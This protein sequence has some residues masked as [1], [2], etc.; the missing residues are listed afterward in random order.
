MA[1]LRTARRP[2]ADTKLAF[3]IKV[4][5]TLTYLDVRETPRW[6]DAVFYAVGSTL[7]DKAC[8]SQLRYLRCD[9]FDVL[10]NVDTLELPERTLGVG[11][12][13]ASADFE[14]AGASDVVVT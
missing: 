1:Y 11:V 13:L 8:T 7:L 3:A 2:T 5:P 14:T 6:D 4:N 10:P 9:S 12:V